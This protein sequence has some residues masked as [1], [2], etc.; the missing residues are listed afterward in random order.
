ML[1]MI[2]YCTSIVCIEIETISVSRARVVE[3]FVAQ[4]YF[5][6]YVSTL[7]NSYQHT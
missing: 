7:Q 1:Q 2:V 5:N 6:S 3:I 4:I